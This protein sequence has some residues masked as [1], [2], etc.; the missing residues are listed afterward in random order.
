MMTANNKHQ[1]LSNVK[2]GH[3]VIVNGFTTGCCMRGRLES[4]GI[5]QGSRILVLKNSRGP[6]LVSNGDC[7]LAIGRHMAEKII[8][9]SAEDSLQAGVG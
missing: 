4:M 1:V 9:S 5:F 6:L 2:P 8:V 3:N 7:R